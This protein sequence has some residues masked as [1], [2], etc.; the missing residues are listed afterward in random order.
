VADAVCADIEG[1]AGVGLQRRSDGKNL[2]QKRRVDPWTMRTIAAAVS[3]S[4]LAACATQENMG[5]PIAFRLAGHAG[6][7][8]AAAQGRRQLRQDSELHWPERLAAA[9]VD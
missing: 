5:P 8:D 1:M 2:P 9:S 6:Q 3:L 7:L 4:L